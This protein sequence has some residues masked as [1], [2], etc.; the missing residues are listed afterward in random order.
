MWKYRARKKNERNHKDITRNR[1]AREYDN[2]KT[3]VRDGD[4]IDAKGWWYSFFAETKRNRA[5][6]SMDFNIYYIY[7]YIY[8]LYIYTYI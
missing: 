7:V 3:C 4:M 8:T 6:M 2:E 1:E 5:S